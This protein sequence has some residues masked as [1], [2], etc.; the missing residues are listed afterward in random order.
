MSGHVKIYN[1]DEA[2]SK[3]RSSRPGSAYPGLAA[4]RA[5][6]RRAASRWCGPIWADTSRIAVQGADQGDLDPARGVAVEGAE[7]GGEQVLGKRQ[8]RRETPELGPEFAPD[9]S[10]LALH[11]GVIAKVDATKSGIPRERSPEHRDASTA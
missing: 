9:P 5:R 4:A 2:A 7:I 10:P 11:R 3:P 8:P 1:Q 6:T